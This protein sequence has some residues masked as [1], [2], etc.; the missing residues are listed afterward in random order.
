M[1]HLLLPIN[2]M[3]LIELM[4]P[5]VVLSVLVLA[6][7][8]R[9]GTLVDF[10]RLRRVLQLLV[11]RHAALEPLRVALGPVPADLAAS[12]RLYLLRRRLWL[13]IAGSALRG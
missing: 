13:A 5:Q 7:A 4:L 3:P 1:H 10:W 6:R 12:V 2:E 8:S 11:L 9:V